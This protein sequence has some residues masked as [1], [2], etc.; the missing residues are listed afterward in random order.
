MKKSARWH[1]P[2]YGEEITLCLDHW[3]TK[4]LLRATRDG[5]YDLLTDGCVGCTA[6]F[7]RLLAGRLIEVAERI[8]RPKRRRKAA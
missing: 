4:V 5:G 8:E 3:G 7:A 1:L 2:K 6:S